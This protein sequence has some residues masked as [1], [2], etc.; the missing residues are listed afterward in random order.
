[1]LKLWGESHKQTLPNAQRMHGLSTLIKVT[2]F[3]SH[4]KL[5][6]IQL[7]NLNKTSASKSW[8]NSS[9]NI[10]TKLKPQNLDQTSP[11]PKSW[12]KIYLKSWP[13]FCFNIL[14]KIQAPNLYHASASKFLSN[15]QH[16]P[17]QQHQQHLQ[18]QKVL[19]CHLQRPES[20]QSSLL[21]RS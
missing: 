18:H 3:K 16:V 4:H 10:S 15:C 19:I 9:F 21:N 5:I 11:L 6:N 2:A 20:H 13:N 12:P 17:K 14:T 1:M 8:P 7:Q